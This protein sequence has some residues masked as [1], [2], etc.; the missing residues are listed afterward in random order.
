MTRHQ[1]RRVFREIGLTES[2]IEATLNVMEQQAERSRKL[3]GAAASASPPTDDPQRELAELAAALGPE[4]AE[5]FM[6]QKKLMPARGQLSMLRSQ[7]DEGGEPLSAEQQQALL[8]KLSER[9]RGP[10][11][12]SVP[13]EDPQQISARFQSYMR[14]RDRDLRDLAAPILSPKQRELMEE[15]LKFQEAVRP[16]ISFSGAA[17]SVAAPPQAGSSAPRAPWN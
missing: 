1:Y 6:A 7:L 9:E 5:R 2:E 12:K 3:S 8:G 10:F 17:P 13:G 4:K 14:E 11:P 15:E 16:Q